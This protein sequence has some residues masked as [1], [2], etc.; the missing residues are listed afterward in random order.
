[1]SPIVN[2]GLVLGV[3]F[4]IMGLL[5][6]WERLTRKDVEYP[7]P[8]IGCTWLLVFGLVGAFSYY[9]W[10][11]SLVPTRET[12]IQMLGWLVGVPVFTFLSKL[13]F[14][15]TRIALLA[16][17]VGLVYGAGSGP[18]LVETVLAIFT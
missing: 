13:I 6:C 12:T 9:V 11:G 18:F 10:Q 8:T 4:V 7:S 15:K 14:C 5:W 1:M 16:V 17:I 3:F 2:L